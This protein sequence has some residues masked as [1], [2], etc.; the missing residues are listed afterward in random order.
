[1]VPAVGLRLEGP[2]RGSERT[3]GLKRAVDICTVI[4]TVGAWKAKLGVTFTR[5]EFASCKR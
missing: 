1:M 2:R 5:A 4:G 3:H